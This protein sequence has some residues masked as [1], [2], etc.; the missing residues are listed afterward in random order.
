MTI[1]AGK[2]PKYNQATS[3]KDTVHFENRTFGV[4][5]HCGPVSGEILFHTGDLVRGGVNL[6]VEIQR[7][8]S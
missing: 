1:Y 6:V 7:L 4:E 3:K 2:T 8:G 5:V